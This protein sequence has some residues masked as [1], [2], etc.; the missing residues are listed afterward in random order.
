VDRAGNV[1]ER[2]APSAEP[3]SLEGDI[4]KLL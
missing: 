1:V 4:A 2:Y 3:E